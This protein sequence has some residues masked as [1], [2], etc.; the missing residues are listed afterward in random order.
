MVSL[1]LSAPGFRCSEELPSVSVRYGCAFESLEQHASGVVAMVRGSDG[2]ITTIDAQYVVGCDGGNSAVRKQ[3]GIALRG[4]G[5]LMR[6]YQAL[7]FCPELYDRIP[8][9][10]GPGHGRHY[11]VADDKATFLIMQDSTR[12]W[13]L[14][15]VVDR[16]EDM[17]VQFERTVGVPVRF[18]MLFRKFE[19]V[20]TLTD[21][22]RTAIRAL[23][24]QALAVKRNHDI[25]REG[26]SPGRCC[27][28]LEGI[29]CW[30]KI[31]STGNVTV[32]IFWLKTDARWRETPMELRHSGSIARRD[33][34]ELTTGIDG[35]DF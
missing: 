32:Q 13:T 35:P 20:F 10:A 19:T 29:A 9:R 6:L 33:V 31:G 16:P 27:V 25:V 34:S 5:D 24:A 11:H 12:H 30:Y 15:S 28:I 14:H 3:L 1:V 22:E 23:P 8:I 26:D 2:G 7:Y 18:D 4:E 17:A 21:R